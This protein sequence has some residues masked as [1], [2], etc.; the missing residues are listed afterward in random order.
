MQALLNGNGSGRLLVNDSGG[1]WAWDAC[2]PNLSRCRPFKH[3]REIST[4]GAAPNSVF[5]VTG[6][7]EVGLS[8]LWKGRVKSVAAPSVHGVFRANERV[9]PVAGRWSGGWAGSPDRLQLAACDTL[10]GQG[11]TTLTHSHFLDR[12]RHEAAVLDPAFTGDYLRVADRRLGAGPIV[13]PAYGV[14]SPYGGE[15]WRRDRTTA[16]A[17]VGRIGEAAGPRMIWC[18]APPIEAGAEA[19]YRR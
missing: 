16:V 3:G 7:G 10:A 9:T 12:C 18:G 19:P 5:R 1:P 13:E 11:C 15:V 8:P 6:E 4:A 14:S 2:S 17:F